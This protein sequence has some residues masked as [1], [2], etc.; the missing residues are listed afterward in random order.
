MQPKR[1]VYADFWDGIEAQYAATGL[2]SKVPDCVKKLLTISGYSS[3]WSFKSV[4]EEKLCEAESFIQNMH[5]KIVDEYEEYKDITPFKFLPG[6]RALIFGIKAEI[7]EFQENKRPKNYVKPPAKLPVLNEKDVV[8]SLLQQMSAFAKRLRIQ[9]DW[10]NSII[11]SSFTATDSASFCTLLFRV[12][13][14][15]PSQSSDTTNIGKQAT[16]TD[17]CVKNM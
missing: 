4:T 11:Q 16:F 8:A 2:N 9:A 10:T 14:V 5:R 13:Y 1:K 17:T 3:K 7:N 12:Q 15:A 6:H